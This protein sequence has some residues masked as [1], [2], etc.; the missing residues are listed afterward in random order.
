MYVHAF[1]NLHRQIYMYHIC[2][3]CVYVHIYVLYVYNVH[4]YIQNKHQIQDLC[5]LTRDIR[6]IL[7]GHI[8][9]F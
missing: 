2:I 9:L 1:E 4:I 8:G 6:L 5:L 7:W 3:I